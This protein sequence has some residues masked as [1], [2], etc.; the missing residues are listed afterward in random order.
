MKQS[1]KILVVALLLTSC[2]KVPITNRKQMNLIPESQITQLSLSEYKE[3]LSQAK[4]VDPKNADAKMVNSVGTKISNAVKLF[5]AQ[6]KLSDRIKGYQWEYNLVEDKAVNAFCMPGGK[7]VVFTGLLPITKDETSLAFVMGHEVA[8]AVARHGNERVS[9]GLAA[10]VGGVALD[11]ALSQKN[12]QT[13]VLAQQAFGMGVS[14]GAILPFSRLHE[15]EA[16]K[17]G[18]V[19]MA[20]AGYDPRVAPEM[21]SRMSAT[22]GQKPPE[23]LSTHPSDAKRMATMKA[24]MPQALKYYKPIKK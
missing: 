12:Q 14:V 6:N 4:V 3:F 2:S 23:F 9:Q 21:W 24:Y 8:H 13:R 1:W 20:M 16:D 7:I 19:F 18:M 15:T 10:Q 17:L 11:V 22:G 5:M